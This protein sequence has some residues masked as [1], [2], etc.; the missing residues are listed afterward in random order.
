MNSVAFLKSQLERDPKSFVGKGVWQ[1][2]PEG[3]VCHIVGVYQIQV[4]SHQVFGEG[5]ERNNV[6]HVLFL[7][8]KSSQCHPCEYDDDD[9][10]NYAIEHIDGTKV[11]ECPMDHEQLHV[12][13]FEHYTTSKPE[14]F[15]TIYQNMGIKQNEWKRYYGWIHM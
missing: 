5:S 8:T 2:F 15:F 9:I 11:V 12:N 13:D 7:A 10:I 4:Q 3:P 1:H 14:T 6:F